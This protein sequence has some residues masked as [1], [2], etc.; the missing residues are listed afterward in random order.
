MDTPRPTRL[1]SRSTADDP[2]DAPAYAVVNHFA[3]G[4]AGSF[5]FLHPHAYSPVTCMRREWASLYHALKAASLDPEWAGY[6]TAI[7]QLAMN[8]F[9]RRPHV[10]AVTLRKSL[11]RCPIRADWPSTRDAVCRQLVLQR[12]LKDA[13]FVNRLL[14]TRSAQLVFRSAYAEDTHWG[15]FRGYGD[16]T[17]GLIYQDVR[18][19]LREIAVHNG[20]PFAGATGA[21]LLFGQAPAVPEREFSAGT[22]CLHGDAKSAAAVPIPEPNTVY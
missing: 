6:D 16:N 13:D 17:L 8:T 10:A 3:D 22:N 15:L 12:A 1:R 20:H 14:A 9:T 21:P 7:D 19:T 11:R 18:A 5:A 2:W 4:F